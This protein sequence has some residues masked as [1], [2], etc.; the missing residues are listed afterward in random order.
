M[1]R[2]GDDIAA[3][4]RAAL[5][6]GVRPAEG[7]AAGIPDFERRFARTRLLASNGSPFLVGLLRDAV[8]HAW[9]RSAGVS[10]DDLTSGGQADV[11]FA[12]GRHRVCRE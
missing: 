8:V 3:A 12:F 11:V 1:R 2:G 7:Y 10:E 4:L 9:V 5:L 6:G